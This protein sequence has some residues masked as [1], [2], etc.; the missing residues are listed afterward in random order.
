MPRERPVLRLTGSDIR[1]EDLRP[2]ASGEVRLELADEARERVAAARS[3]VD[4]LLAGDDVAYGVNTGFGRFCRIR[5]SPEQVRELQV[6]LVRSHAAGV[7]EPLSDPVV[8]LA[9]ALR[10]NTLARGNSGIRPETLELLMSLYNAEVIPW[11]PCQGSVGASGDL[12]PL[13]HLA[14]VLIGEGKARVDEEWV[15]GKRALESAGLAPVQL[16][17]KEGL[18][19]INGV[20]ISCALLSSALLVAA[21]VLE[22]ADLAGAMS[23]EAS[24]GSLAP[25]DAR[26]HDVRPHPGQAQVAA[27]FRD[28]IE[29]SEILASHKDCGRVQDAYSLRCIPQVHGAVKDAMGFVVDTLLREANAATDNPLIFPEEGDIISGG[30]FHGAPVGY[31]ADLLGIVLADL[32]SISERRTERLVNPDLSGLPAFL[33]REEGLQSGFMSA[34]V[35]AAALVSENKVLAHP[36]SVD[37]ITTSAA[38]EDHVSMSTHA[39]SKAGSI[40]RN[41]ERIVAIELLVALE[42]FEH[43]RPL[44]SGEALEEKMA[45]LRDRIPAY[46]RDRELHGDIE[47]VAQ[48][49]RSGELEF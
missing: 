3:V 44:R 37:S 10:A 32:G 31:G 26:I 16:E 13:A 7:G 38:T 49:I 27:R 5:I 6:N 15:P 12:A 41:T 29:G 47:C 1:F 11:I 43:R 34:Q 19:L 46:T 23:L 8:R 45:L 17:A 20:Q 2:I 33:S 25:F 40:A 28:I 4:A 39:A 48:L 18:A 9:L 30:N 42:A 21:R 35:T 22:A 24:L 14:Q 36:A